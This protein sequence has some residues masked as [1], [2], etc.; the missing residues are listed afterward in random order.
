MEGTPF[1]TPPEIFKEEFT[2]YSGTKFDIWSSGVT[3]YEMVSGR[4]PFNDTE[5]G[6]FDSILVDE[7]NYPKYILE[8]KQLLD[9]LQCNTE[10]SMF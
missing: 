5:L 4:M 1:Y 9:L 2:S 8:D 6:F 7:V 10:Y 3:L